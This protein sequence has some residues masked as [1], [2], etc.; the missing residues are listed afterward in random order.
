M[1]YKLTNGFQ[2]I[3][4]SDFITNWKTDCSKNINLVIKIV[5][6]FLIIYWVMNKMSIV[7]NQKDYPHMYHKDGT[8]TFVNNNANDKMTDLK[9]LHNILTSNCS[10]KYCNA[11]SWGEKV[12]LPEN[13]FLTNFSTNGGCCVI[14]NE[15]RT[16]I[17]GN[18]GNNV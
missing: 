10:P 12:E 4:Y 17:Y 9:Q 13:H 1:T 5:I 14:P 7:K 15:I 11:T 8:E 6:L 16:I 3:S 2:S 18:R